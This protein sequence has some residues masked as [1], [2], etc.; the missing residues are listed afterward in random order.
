MFDPEK[1]QS[2]ELIKKEELPDVLSTGWLLRHKKS[3]AR[4]AL[5]ENKDENKVFNIAFR[6]TPS[7]STGVA[8]IMEHCVLCGSRKYPAKDPFIELVKGSMNTFLNAMTYPDKTMYPVAS[9]NDRDFAN[10]MS[11][12]MDA[13][14]YPNIYTRQ[15]IFRQEG[16]HYELDDPEGELAYNGVV[17]NEMKGA[18]SS[19]D[20]VVEREIMQRL[21]PDTTYHHES[22]GDPACIPDLTYEE[23][24]EFHRTYYH[25]SN[26]YIYLYG[27][28]DFNERLEWLDREYLSDFDRISVDSEVTIQEPFEKMQ[29]CE[30]EYPVGDEDPVEKN[31]YLT[32]SAV[33]GTSLDTKLSN[34]FAILEYVLLEMPG[35]P[36]K[37]ALLEEGLGSDIMS[38]YDSGTLQPGFSVIAKGADEADSARFDEVIR[39]TLAKIADEGVDQDALKAAINL[40]EFRFREADYGTFPKGLMYGVDIFDS[41]LYDDGKPF[42]YLWSLRDYDFLKSQIGTGYFEGL[43]R[44]WLL[45]NPHC[46]LLTAIPVRSLTEKMQEREAARLAAYRE[47]LGEEQ[48]RALVSETKALHE[49]QETPSSKEDLEKIPML[50]ISDLNR[51]IRKFSNE[52]HPWESALMVRHDFETN[53]IAYIDLLF[54]AA[55]V[56]QEDLVWLGLL[57]T[58]LGSVDTASYSYSQLSTAVG[59]RTGGISPL[60]SI[61]PDSLDTG[62]TS[63]AFGLR[64]RTLTQEIPFCF[65]I[66]EEML[67]TSDLAQEK[68]LREL[69]FKQRSRLGTALASSGNATAV[70][71]CMSSFS[72]N[73][74][75]SDQIGGVAYYDFVRDLTDHFDE[76]K[77]LM[78]Q[79]LSETLARVLGGKVLVSYTGSAD[80]LETI[81]T[82]TGHLVSRCAQKRE[83]AASGEDLTK[84]F[85][86]Y[87]LSFPEPVNEALRTPGQVQYVARCGNFRKNGA[88]YHGAMTVLRTIMSFDYLWNNVRVTGGAYGC[89]GNLLRNGDTSFS[90]YRDPN[91]RRTDE[92]FRGIPDYLDSFDPDERDMTKYIIGTI[93]AIDTPL[94]P[95]A[96]GSVSML[97]ALDGRTDEVRQKTRD[98]ILSATA[99]DIRALAQQVRAAL[100]GSH[101]CVVG[102]AAGIEADK[103]L[104][105]TVREL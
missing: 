48:I 103:E 26:S 17:F 16:W 56:P 94:T 15:E 89:G 92:V 19:A 90:S 78:A 13:V 22:G 51:E 67:F 11:V 86:T 33:V 102:S 81:R 54:D 50:E 63:L 97:T 64:C 71:R 42:D 20:E 76:K 99:G 40:M 27:D 8:H 57:R 85:E 25:P 10:L 75:I 46:L 53:G 31:A 30:T 70:T 47:T 4:I 44:T 98:Q 36:L 65:E 66:M 29:V 79:K 68:R 6:T 83:T 84:Y 96:L 9:C 14:F 93:S 5:L 101:L 28:M 34:A 58:M 59:S 38:S 49:Y 3:G 61:F 95:S 45:E 35:A 91:L 77:P 39:K 104:F 60:I 24:L 52:I 2:Y 12:Y 55:A 72:A 73:A 88:S 1:L 7:N 41:W 87:P 62:R 37:E 100:E 82:G 74:L 69:L 105:D 80:H 43:I 21:F 32:W 23:F 18:F